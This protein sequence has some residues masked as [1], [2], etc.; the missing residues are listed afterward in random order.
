[1]TDLGQALSMGSR[2]KRTLGLNRSGSLCP[3]GVL[4]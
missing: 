1:M 2:P 4:I 3:T